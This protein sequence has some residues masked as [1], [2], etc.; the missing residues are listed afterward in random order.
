MAD[1]KEKLKREILKC[2]E[3]LSREA[4]ELHV[5]SS[6]TEVDGEPDSALDFH[7]RD[8]GER[9]LVCIGIDRVDVNCFGSIFNP[10]HMLFKNCITFF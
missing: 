6:V 3:N 5:G 4:K 9:G 8:H 7:R 1:D 2:C 10:Y